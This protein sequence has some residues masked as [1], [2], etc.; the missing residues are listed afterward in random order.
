MVREGTIPPL[1]RLLSEG[2][3]D[4]KEAA[5][6]ALWNL[7]F[8]DDNQREIAT[9]GAIPMLVQLLEE[10]SSGTAVAA[11]GVLGKLGDSAQ[12][13]EVIVGAGAIPALVKLV[14]GGEG[15]TKEVAVEA[16]WNIVSHD[17]P[18][19]HAY[20]NILKAEEPAEAL[21]GFLQDRVDRDAQQAASQL[22]GKLSEW[23]IFDWFT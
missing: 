1:V 11:A 15:R 16:L 19:T 20:K 17:P 9:I 5:A 22:L 8:D 14:K 12:H 18:G 2:T 4:A 3:E 21:I 13:C 23:S 7:A 6:G 10:P